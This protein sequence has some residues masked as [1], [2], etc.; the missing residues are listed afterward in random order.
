MDTMASFA[1]QR[2][3]QRRRRYFDANS[4]VVRFTVIAMMLYMRD[5]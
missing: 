5:T 2:T 1:G 3:R 4:G